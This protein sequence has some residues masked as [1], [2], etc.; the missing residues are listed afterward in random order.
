MPCVCYVWWGEGAIWTSEEIVRSPGT[1]VTGG[2][3]L[4]GV[5]AKIQT[6]SSRTAS[7]AFACWALSLARCYFLLKLLR[8]FYTLVQLEFSFPSFRKKELGWIKTI[9]ELDSYCSSVGWLS[10]GQKS[11]NRCHWERQEKLPYPG[12][13]NTHP[14]PAQCQPQ[15]SLE[16]LY[17]LFK[18]SQAGWGGRFS[19][20]SV[21][22]ADWADPQNQLVQKTGH[23]D[24]FFITPVLE[25][26]CRQGGLGNQ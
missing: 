3:E 10:L 24:N 21:C 13:K 5:D 12:S 26:W 16:H 19:W 4:P 15:E 18:R 17:A 14:G 20:S 23:N 7:S 8:L 22:R 11:S 9:Q 2:C 6:R 1:R 25:T